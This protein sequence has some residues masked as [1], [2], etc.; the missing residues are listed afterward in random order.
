MP[1]LDWCPYSPFSL[2]SKLNVYCYVQLDD[3]LC[4]GHTYF[5]IDWDGEK[6]TL[7]EGPYGPIPY[8]PLDASVKKTGVDSSGIA[9][10]LFSASISKEGQ[11]NSSFSL[12]SGPSCFTPPAI[13]EQ[14]G[15][16]VDPGCCGTVFPNVPFTEIRFYSDGCALSKWQSSRTS[17]TM[18]QRAPGAML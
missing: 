7:P 14:L 6:Y 4:I 8:G 10:L 3:L 1:T 12:V 18:F 11:C 17:R 2:P 5:S 16:E 9:E 13:L 15:G